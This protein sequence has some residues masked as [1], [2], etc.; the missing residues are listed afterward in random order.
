MRVI[1]LK[2]RNQVYARLIAAGLCVFALIAAP[3][4]IA[5]P[6]YAFA[7]GSGTELDPYQIST[8]EQLASLSSY[9]GSSHS[10]KYFELVN[11]IDLGV[12]PYNTGTGWTPIGMTSSSSAF[13]GKFDGNGYTIRNLYSNRTTSYVG[14]FGYLYTGA[15]VQNVTVENASVTGSAGRVG[16]LAGASY[17]ATIM[18]VATSGAVNAGGIYAGGLV[19]HA[20]LSTIS[21]SHSSASVT[22]TSSNVGGLVG[23][24]E[25]SSAANSTITNSYATGDVRGSS[26]VGGFAG[27]RYQGTINQSYATGDVLGDAAGGT[28]NTVSGGFVG[29]H[30]L[31][32]I[33][34]S[35]ATGDV[36]GHNYLGG[37]AGYSHNCGGSITNSY[38]RGDV[39]GTPSE[40]AG[41]FI[42]YMYLGTVSNSYATGSVSGRTNGGFIQYDHTCSSC[43]NNFWDTQT[44]GQTTGGTFAGGRATGKT[45][46]QMKDIAT[47]TDTATTGLTSAW[48]FV[49]TENDDTATSEYWAIDANINDGYPYLTWYTPV[50]TAPDVTTLGPTARVTG[51]WGND[52]AVSLSFV[53]SDDEGDDVQYRLQVDDSSDFSSPLVDTTSAFAAPGSRSY[54][55][56]DPLENGQYYWRVKAIDGGGAESPYRVANAGAVAFGID[57]LAPASPDN[58]LQISDVNDPTP[59]LQIEGSIDAGGSGLG[60]PAY[61][62]EWSQDVSFTTGVMS[63][64]TNS[65]TYTVP[66][67]LADGRWYT[68]ATAFDAAGNSTLSDLGNFLIDTTAP[69]LQQM[70]PL[71]GAGGVSIN[72][73]LSMQFDQIVGAVSGDIVIRKLADDS[74]VETIPVGGGPVAGSGTDTIRIDP[75]YPLE[76]NT[77]YYVEIDGTAIDDLHRNYYAGIAGRT[78]WSFTTMAEPSSNTPDQVVAQS[79]ADSPSSSVA[80]APSTPASSQTEVRAEDGQ[81][82]RLDDFREYLIGTGKQL[83]VATGQVIYFMHDGEQHSVTVGAVSGDSVLVTVASTPETF[84]LS[85]GQRVGHDVDDD[86]Q[87][88]IGIALIALTSEGATLSFTKVAQGLTQPA[89]DAE[90]YGVGQETPAGMSWW[91]AG[92]LLAGLALLVGILLWIWRRSARRR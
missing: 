48:D 76:Y 60:D 49:G 34:R 54:T 41:G 20:N 25:A 53:I 66:S 79:D 58:P 11:D 27:S 87:E 72:P 23:Y 26:N 13:Y 21:D 15:V 84:S 90:S 83:E 18:N 16:I 37:F 69:V 7:A 46:A 39:Y 85:I 63:V 59:E 24:I 89:E 64:T 52:N 86:G 6:T 62:F 75:Y 74:I 28:T 22:S 19:G 12:A 3:L 71:A 80:V 29:G 5:N 50:N 91:V 1:S 33:T 4:Y 40:T 14:V 44:S 51:A 45:T 38:A 82:V 61:L 30:C 88:D 92:S 67:A 73:T 8:A 17:N 35:F 70:T 47:F 56:D 31:G 55:L 77:A 9:L 78:T 36:Y 42:G 32:V 10:G 2:R 81:P 57:I 43:S 65:T 68:R